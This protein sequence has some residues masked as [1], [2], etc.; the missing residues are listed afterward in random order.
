V[1]EV[2]DEKKPPTKRPKLKH[3]AIADPRWLDASFLCGP[4]KKEIKVNRAVL[5]SM[6]PVLH[7]ILYGTGLI[8]VDPSK[9]IEWP[10][11]D[12]KAVRQVFLALLHCG[13]KEFVVPMESVDSAKMLVDYL[14]ETRETL[15]LYYDTPFK[16]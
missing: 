5:A 11:F 4:Q 8:S 1:L 14:L 16:R 7:R 9:P 12:A 6:N 3:P 15:M 13:K 2:V 10:D